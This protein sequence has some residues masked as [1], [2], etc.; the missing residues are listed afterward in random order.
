[1][2][3]LTEITGKKV[4]EF[5]HE[6][7]A[8]RSTVANADVRFY[9]SM[10]ARKALRTRN[11]DMSR[12]THILNYLEHLAKRYT[13]SNKKTAPK[14]L[15]VKLRWPGK[16]LGLDDQVGT[17]FDNAKIILADLNAEK[18]K[19]NKKIAK[20]IIDKLPRKLKITKDIL[21]TKPKLKQLKYLEKLAND[22]NWSL[23]DENTSPNR[24]VEHR[25]TIV[26]RLMCNKIS[27]KRII[28]IKVLCK[29]KS[30]NQFRMAQGYPDTGTLRNVESYSLM[31]PFI[32]KEENPR[33]IA[34]ITNSSD[35]RKFDETFAGTITRT[36]YID[37]LAEAEEKKIDIKP[38]L[39]SNILEEIP[40]SFQ[41]IG[42]GEAEIEKEDKRALLL[43]LI[44]DHTKECSLKSDER[45]RE[46]LRLLMARRIN[47]FEV[48]QFNAQMSLLSPI[49]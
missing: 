41:E 36:T 23:E 5:L 13:R 4:E 47:A 45:E 3:R 34:H 11:V 6:F 25:K 19:A 38:I 40:E 49:K 21:N 17:F 27:D 33:M 22:R 32:S 42:V 1:M 24:A 14:R 43:K 30:T 20:I 15:K 48:H 9:L 16:D 2:T 39:A 8:F 28:K 37:E 10:K 29:D 31:K 26:K 35:I 7:K 44:D 46:R 18:R 12:P